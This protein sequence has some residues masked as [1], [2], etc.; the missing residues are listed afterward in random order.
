MRKRIMCARMLGERKGVRSI[1]LRGFIVTEI[2]AGQRF[3]Y[4]NGTRAESQDEVSK[5]EHMGKSYSLT[6][7]L[8]RYK[9]AI[10]EDKAIR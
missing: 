7:V 5:D 4:R 2:T 6:K 8:E 10:G 1:F 3:T 9:K